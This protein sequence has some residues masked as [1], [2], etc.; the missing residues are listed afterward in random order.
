MLTSEPCCHLHLRERTLLA[1]WVIKE[2]K[3][4]VVRVCWRELKSQGLPEAGVGSEF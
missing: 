1:V 4:G 2:K 3:N